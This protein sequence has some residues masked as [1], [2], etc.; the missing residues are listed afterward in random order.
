[1]VLRSLLHTEH[2]MAKVCPVVDTLAVQK[3]DIFSPSFKMTVKIA[4]ILLFKKRTSNQNSIP[5]PGFCIPFWAFFWSSFQE[6][7]PLD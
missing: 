5:K 2:L 6:A 7:E 1:M 3:L 4:A